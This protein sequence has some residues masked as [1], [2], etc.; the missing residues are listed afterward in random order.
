MIFIFI[1]FVYDR[2]FDSKRLSYSEPRWVGSGGCP[3]R[4][5]QAGVPQV[6]QAVHQLRRQ[7][8]QRQAVGHLALAPPAR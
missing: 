6:P 1:Y 5:L 8:V 7:S 2:L 3:P 4:R